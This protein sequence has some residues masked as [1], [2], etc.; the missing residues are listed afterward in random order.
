[1]GRVVR[2]VPG[3][4]ASIWLACNRP[5]GSAYVDA[6]EDALP[7][8]APRLA[9]PSAPDSGPPALGEI[10][11]LQGKAPSAVV[12]LQPDKVLLTLIAN[13][14][15]DWTRSNPDLIKLG[16]SN[17]GELEIEVPRDRCRFSSDAPT[18]HHCLLV[19]SVGPSVPTLAVSFPGA[20]DSTRPA[21]DWSGVPPGAGARVIMLDE[22]LDYER[23]TSAEGERRS[24][25]L[26][27]TMNI[28]KGSAVAGF[29]HVFS[30]EDLL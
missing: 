24:W 4:L 21:L 29:R 9:S 8:A 30:A 26:T 5:G 22:S 6:H 3:L 18:V 7:A 19:A 2:R 25:V 12:R 11:V 15:F 14:F 27:V 13:G 28:Q 20:I 16:L 10:T 1:M 17:V 23:V